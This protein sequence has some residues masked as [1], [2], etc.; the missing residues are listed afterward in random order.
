MSKDKGWG[1]SLE[2]LNKQ[3]EEASKRP[4]QKL[5]PEI[6]EQDKVILDLHKL[7]KEEAEQ[8]WEKHLELWRKHGR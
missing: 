3:A 6:E 1:G 5:P 2:H 8:L 4:G 7:H